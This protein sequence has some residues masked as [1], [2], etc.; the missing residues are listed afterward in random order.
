MTAP[1]VLSVLGAAVHPGVVL[2]DAAGCPHT[3]LRVAEYP[4]RFVG[5]RA[6]VAYGDGWECTVCDRQRYHIQRQEVTR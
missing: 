4:G 1:P 2:V 3:V 6:R 5:D